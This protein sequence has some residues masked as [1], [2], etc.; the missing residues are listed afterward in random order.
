MT[1]A[2]SPERPPLPISQSSSWS[3]HEVRDS[4]PG[5]RF[6]LN[7]LRVFE[8]FNRGFIEF[9]RSFIGFL[10]VLNEFFDFLGF[11]KLF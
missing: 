3:S 4:G 2:D 5:R 7:G 10:K 11:S 9:Y 8:E 1:S 6:L